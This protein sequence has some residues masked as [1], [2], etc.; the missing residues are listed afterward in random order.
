M[1]QKGPDHWIIELRDLDRAFFAQFAQAP[2]V[3]GAEFGDPARI[4]GRRRIFDETLVAGGDTVPQA[5][6]DSE[7]ETS[8]GFVKAGVVV[9]SGNPVQAKVHVHPRAH[10]LARV[11]GTGLERLN[12]I[13]TWQSYNNCAQP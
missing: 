10:P 5:P 9:V 1:G 12:D 2:R 8:A 13:A 3:V 11:N 7:A 4:L 6:V